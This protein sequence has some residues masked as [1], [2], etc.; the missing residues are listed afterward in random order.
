MFKRR[1]IDPFVEVVHDDGILYYLLVGLG[2]PLAARSLQDWKQCVDYCLTEWREELKACTL[3]VTES[4][5]EY[6]VSWADHAILGACVR[7]NPSVIELLLDW[8][9]NPNTFIPSINASPLHTL[10]TR[11]A[12]WREIE[13]CLAPLLAAGMTWKING[14]NVLFYSLGYY[15]PRGFQWLI[16][17]GAH[18]SLTDDMMLELRGKIGRSYRPSLADKMLDTLRFYVDRRAMPV[19]GQYVLS[20]WLLVYRPPKRAGQRRGGVKL[21]PPE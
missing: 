12:E 13:R 9:C 11:S 17:H 15:H 5:T 1:E 20:D 16:R 2:P 19:P 3:C 7:C 18:E 10:L 4:G 14:I 6:N 21:P 8:G